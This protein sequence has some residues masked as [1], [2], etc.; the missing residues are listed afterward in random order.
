M[1]ALLRTRKS[2]LAVWLA[3]ISLAI[4]AITLS[5]FDG[6]AVS[7]VAA[8]SQPGAAK[9]MLQSARAALEQ[10]I[11]EEK[12]DTSDEARL[13]VERALEFYNSAAALRVREIE[14][15]LEAI[16]GQYGSRQYGETRKLE[17]ILPGEILRE[18]R[19]LRAELQ[20]LKTASA[21]AQAAD[22]SE[23]EPNNSPT[24]AN[25]LDLISSRQTVTGAITPASD[26]DY[27]S[28]NAPA[29][30]RLWASVDTGGT[31]ISGATSR[32]SILTLFG[33]DGTTVIEEDND[34]GIGN[35]CDDTNE[36]SAASTIAGR[37]LSAA[38][39][40]YLRVRASGSG[41]I[42]PYALHIALT[43]TA[44]VAE[45]EPN[46]S[47]STANATVNGQTPLAVR[48]G[49]ISPSGDS[50][51]YSITVAGSGVIFISVDGDPERDGTGTDTVVALLSPTGSQLFSADSSFSGSA[52]NPPA[53]TFCFL[54]PS[55]GVYTVRVRHFSSSSTGS[56]LLMV[57]ADNAGNIAN[58][59]AA[60][61]LGGTLAP[62]SIVATFGTNIAPSTQ[63]ANST[64]LPTQLAGTRLMVRDRTG[65]ERAASLFFVSGQ[66][67]NFLMPPDTALGLA[68]V[69]VVNPSGSSLS[70]AVRI[71]SVAPGLFS[72]N[73]SGKD[74]AAAVIV[75]VKAN[76][77]QIT[78][79]VAR[80][81]QN[82]LVPIPI[83]LGPETDQVV[84]VLFGTGL[85]KRSA[86]S[87]VTAKIGID[88][89][90][91]LFAGAQGG[92]FGLDQVNLLLSRQLIGYGELPVQ[93]TVDGQTT[94]VVTI[95]IGG[96][97]PAPR[98]VAMQPDNGAQ[99]RTVAS[100]S[101]T[102]VPLG[103][104]TG[105][106]FTPPDGV[107]VSNLKAS[108]FGVTA[109]V[110]IAADAPLGL[111]TVTVISPAGR[112]NGLSF[113]VRLPPPPQITT[114]SQRI[115]VPGQSN[116]S[117]V[118]TGTD[119]ATVN[120]VEVTPGN[121]VTISNPVAT[122]NSV[123]AQLSIAPNA[124][125]GAYS[126]TV[127]SPS[128]RSNARTFQ[129]IAPPTSNVPT[130]SNLTVNTPTLVGSN[131]LLTGQVDFTDANGDL[132]FTGSQSTSARLRFVLSIGLSSC[133]ITGTGPF[134]N[135]PGQ[136]AGTVNF[137]MTY[138]PGSVSIGTFS[139]SFT[140]ID[141]AGNSSNTL[142]FSPGVWLCLSRPE[143]D[144]SPPEAI[145][146]LVAEINS[147]R[148]PE[149]RLARKEREIF[150]RS[151]RERSTAARLSLARLS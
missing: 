129:V 115:G 145:A 55:A 49:S 8:Q 74:V 126:V 122:G 40:Y 93:L 57:F 7:P 135:L 19:E 110:A 36:S 63:T 84:L 66:Q 65:T 94:N 150:N 52:T 120:A 42:N 90:Q 96:P 83:D 41:L 6:A 130:V 14:E 60:S 21:S 39:V 3:I 125:L 34:D 85:R 138:S 101:I 12:N 92:F 71:A 2:Y 72:A 132:V 17:E 151:L 128:G 28:F 15:R 5:L 104:V 98:I 18:W 141:A 77:Q 108:P 10:A 24:E 100:L 75:R 44:P 68:S 22:A 48:S 147:S 106:E 105:L 137:A 89:A 62:D 53:E 102:G 136:V 80:V 33:P 29:G 54:V 140:L 11:A 86:L 31:Q 46:N 61:F 35:G 148:R 67:A 107:T 114:I 76:G 50:D 127:V 131:A 117:F 123:T 111:R 87:A 103:G 1:R 58:V 91:A 56:Y 82:R 73:A 51:F 118:I 30:A 113:E 124:S 146:P 88:D 139:V 64:P 149:R 134:L 99:G 79:P 70:G 121:G 81:E 47:T 45:T 112:S 133:T 143:R 119:M 20:A 9:A 37:T 43:T 142:S 16:S 38:G 59:S 78:E 13:A 144:E 4:L 25:A 97:Q 32:D 27:F 109:Q 26:A 23:I 116:S 95:N 69:R